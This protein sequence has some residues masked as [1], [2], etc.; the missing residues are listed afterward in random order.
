MRKKRILAVASTGG[1]WIQ[2]R[3]ISPA[4]SGTEVTYVSTNAGHRDELIGENCRYFNVTDA[5]RWEKLKLIKMFMDVAWVLLRVRPDVILTTGAAPGFAALMFGRLM[6]ART[7]W[8]DSIANAEK[9]SDSGLK[10]H[11]WAD[12]WLTQWEH[13]AKE[14]GPHYWG[15]V[16]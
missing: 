14:D 3:R 5:N 16:L 15:G 12:V 7:I 8:V 9:M 13:L 11:R 6:G 10:V 2:L 1:H 4:F